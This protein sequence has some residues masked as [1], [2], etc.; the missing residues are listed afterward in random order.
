MVTCGNFMFGSRVNL[1]EDGFEGV[2][3]DL[4]LLSSHIVDALTPIDGDHI[5]W[6]EGGNKFVRE[7]AEVGLGQQTGKGVD[8]RGEDVGYGGDVVRLVTHTLDGRPRHLSHCIQCNLDLRFNPQHKNTHC[9][10]NYSRKLLLLGTHVNAVAKLLVDG[11]FDTLPELPAGLEAVVGGVDNQ[12]N[13]LLVLLHQPH[14]L[15][16]LRQKIGRS[17]RRPRELCGQCIAVALEILFEDFAHVEQ[18]RIACKCDAL[19][20]AALDAQE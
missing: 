8:A 5:A 17:A 3:I 15:F 16:L 4:Q 2:R 12:A 7:E 14:V 13:R 10:C 19:L 20:Q 9:L 6:D 1:E 11:L 18:R